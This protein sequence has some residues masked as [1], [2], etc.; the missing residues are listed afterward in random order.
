MVSGWR[1][2][3]LAVLAAS[4]ALITSRQGRAPRSDIE[5]IL[6]EKFP[7]WRV[8]INLDRFIRIGYLSKDEHDMLYIGW[9]SRAE[10]DQ[11][12]LMEL[13]LAK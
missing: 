6:R 1:I 5:Q 4:I 9:R 3:D 11:K 7:K 2:D 12:T 13:L 8:D 10:I